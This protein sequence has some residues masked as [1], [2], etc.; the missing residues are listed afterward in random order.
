M[1]GLGR[2]VVQISAGLVSMGR[3]IEILKIK[4]EELD[5]GITSSD[6]KML[7]EINFD[8]VGFQYDEHSRVLKDIS[9]HCTTGQSV[10]LLGPTGSGKTTLVNLLPRLYEYN[11]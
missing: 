7:G 11:Q 8:G 10:A 3:I 9:F 2:L 5:F 6:C 1:G 4:R